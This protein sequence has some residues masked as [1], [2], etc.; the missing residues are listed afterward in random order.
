MSRVMARLPPRHAAWLLLLP[1]LAAP[2]AAASTQPPSP[3]TTCVCTAPPAA[4]D[5][6]DTL[7]L[8]PGATLAPPL[9][10]PLT[11]PARALRQAHQD[12]TSASPRHPSGHT[13]PP[14]SPASSPTQQ[15][16]TGAFPA[17]TPAPAA[18][19]PRASAS[20]APAHTPAPHAA[21][22]LGA[23]AG[24][25][26]LAGVAL[27][28]AAVT[29]TLGVRRLR[30]RT[31]T[32]RS[33]QA[34]VPA[35]APPGSVSA[36]TAHDSLSRL[37]LALRALA[38]HAGRAE[39]D[40][41]PA[42]R[43]ALITP[44]TVRLLP[45][46]SALTAPAPFTTGPDGW[47][48]L[49]ADIDLS[50]DTAAPAGPAPYPALVTIGS[51]EAGDLVLLNLA[52]TPAVLLDGST[53]Q[54]SEVCTCLAL[55]LALSPWADGVEI[56]TVGF[57]DDLPPL[58][59]PQPITHTPHA[60]H[61]LRDLG[62]RLLEAHQMPNALHQP[63]VVL[64][65][66]PL[67]T[68]T[69]AE[70][71]DVIARAHTLPVTLIAPAGAAAALFPHAVLLDA[72]L[73]G[74]QHLHPAAT[75][76]RLQRLEHTA[77]Q[78]IIT[79]LHGAVWHTGPA[80]PAPQQTDERPAGIASG[81]L[82]ATAPDARNSTSFSA[83]LAAGDPASPHLPSTGTRNRIPGQAQHTPGPH[84]CEPAPFTVPVPATAPPEPGHHPGTDRAVSDDP[85][86]PEIRVLG[87]VEVTG[88][89]AT[90][91]GPR[92]A[93]LAA[94]LYFR[95]GRSAD[96]LCTDMDPANPWSTTTLNA[97][98]QGLRRA[99]GND[100]A[101]HP[102][103]PRR[104]SGDAPYRLAPAVRCDWTRFL[105][106]TEHAL[107]QGPTGLPQLEEAL[108]LVRGRPFGT[109]PL[110]WAQ[111]HQQE[112]ITRIVHTAHIVATHRTPPGPHHNLTTARHAIATGLDTDDSA[113]LLYRDW[114]RIEDAAG[115]R[116]G[117]HTAITRI[118]HLTHTLDAPLQPETQHLIHQL[119]HPAG[120]ERQPK[121]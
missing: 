100:P 27:A 64:C 57:G 71:A 94:L 42:V 120:H 14:H 88:V 16:T 19:A 44:H 105:N 30:R 48:T 85:H 86:A 99:L 13:P 76:I 39:A 7:A 31:H 6:S 73:A 82:P 113:E 67:D 45:E 101:G 61:A 22:G 35:L 77:Y 12:L 52:R 74:P 83:L 9:T 36:P 104:N 117:L 15:P 26:A 41:V 2:P 11:A 46:A 106:L 97:R 38:H 81:P 5:P 121:P 32:N 72:S 47:W 66:S 114:I 20:P 3:A 98:L 69:A 92:S 87:P 93:Q 90:G 95:P 24:Y 110:P 115:N 33:A 78:Q 54:I 102:Y 103:V 91:H 59:T 49:P 34:T 75:D 8:S 29:A 43:A 56:V 18:S 79:T 111:P 96:T 17:L 119:L 60:A 4:P 21:P 63:Y 118:Q 80:E 65:A 1:A 89:P 10:L 55:E 68:A 50:H 28:A 23:G 84:E 40:A 112:M 37:D 62:E 109:R 51:T 58:P 70:F 25:E 107:T 108:A 53:S 116:P